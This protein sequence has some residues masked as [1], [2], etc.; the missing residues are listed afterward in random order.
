MFFPHRTI[1]L[2]QISG[3]QQAEPPHQKV[4]L[5]HKVSAVHHVAAGRMTIDIGQS[6]SV[7]EFSKKIWQVLA[8]WYFAGLQTVV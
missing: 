7:G 1:Q 6:Q 3:S 5:Q 8:K 2:F 4:Y